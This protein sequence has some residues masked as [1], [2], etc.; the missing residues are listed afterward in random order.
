MTKN[1]N[2]TPG[3]N[4]LVRWEANAKGSVPVKSNFIDGKRIKKIILP[5]LTR[6]TQVPKPGETWVCRVERIT[7]SN[8]ESRG[9][10]IV[11]PLAM[12]IDPSFPGVYVEPMKARLMSIVLQNREKNLML[13]GDQGIGKSTIARAVATKLGWKFRKISGGL[14]KKF[15]YMLGR[16]LPA[17]EQGKQVFKWFDSAL[18]RAIRE[19]ARNLDHTFLIMIDEYSRMDEDAR[20]A[21]LDVIEGDKR[22]IALTNGDLVDIPG[23]V[24]FMAAA[25]EGGPFTV[26]KA[27]AAAKDRWVIVKIEHMPQPEEL[28]HCLGKFPNCPKNTLDQALTIINRLRSMRHDL[29]MRLSQTISTR[30]A[31]NV[32]MFLASGIDLKVALMTAVANQF[33]GSESDQNSEAGR[34][35]K[36]INDLLKQN[37]ATPVKAAEAAEPA[38]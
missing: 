12:E 16:L 35:A 6:R 9:A 37:T 22:S 7:N 33:E 5:E 10:I 11:K 26:R 20:D 3:T 32:A 38:K 8:A 19:A 17:E 13:I 24:R 4:C 23:N 34:V 15:A 1:V 36:T 18:V 25:N 21:L 27:D 14:V 31:Q 28:A 30:A 2:P 29:K